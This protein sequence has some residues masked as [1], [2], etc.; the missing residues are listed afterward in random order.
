MIPDRNTMKTRERDGDRTERVIARLRSIARPLASDRD[1][2]PLIERTGDARHVLLGEA[3]HG[4]AEF[5]TWRARLTRRLIEEKDFSFVAVEGDWPDCSRVNRYVKGEGEAKSAWEVLHAFDRWP[6]WMWANREVVEFV[7]WLRAHNTKRARDERVGFYGLDVYSL[8]DSMSAVVGYLDRVD[9]EAAKRARRA[10]ECFAPFGEDEQRYARATALTPISCE[11]A[12][13]RAL[14]EL[15]RDAARADGGGREAHFEAEQNALIARNAELY[16]RTMIRGGPASWNVRDGHM[17]ETLD[18]LMDLHGPRAKCVVWEHNT[19][20]GDARYTDMAD[21]GEFN[22]GQKVREAHA[23]EDVVVVGFSTHRGTVIAAEEWDA[24]MALMRV[25]PGRPGTYEDLLYRVGGGD[26]M[27]VFDDATR[28]GEL[29]DARGHRAIGVVYRP[30]YEHYGNYVP[31]VLP[32]RYDAM[33]FIEATHGV[34]PLH[35]IERKDGEAA[36]TFPT[37][38]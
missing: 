18:R 3:S 12:V 13:V 26:K 29:L 9:P 1:L 21:D 37:G 25:P 16:Y 31:T 6:T 14:S 23:R 7:E 2:D 15:R 10:Y 30:R 27:L 24:P 8:W 5:Y 33:L 34:A 35:L 17:V 11:D 32:L 38:M 28:T 19:H 36:E 20:V 4:T 22:V